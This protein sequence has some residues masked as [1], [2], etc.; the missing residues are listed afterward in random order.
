M[1][2]IP[3]PPEFNDTLSDMAYNLNVKQINDNDMLK[4]MLIREI[5]V[6]NF[7]MSEIETSLRSIANEKQ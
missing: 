7:Y 2:N 5:K 3:T 1:D 6:L 4:I